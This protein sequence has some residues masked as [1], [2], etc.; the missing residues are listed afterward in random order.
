M[1]TAEG[2]SV[3]AIAVYRGGAGYSWRGHGASVIA[4]SPATYTGSEMN[5]LG[6]GEV[7][8]RTVPWPDYHLSGFIPLDG[9]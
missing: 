9:G 3:G 7:N 4:G 1:P 8:T 2:R 6:W 5:L